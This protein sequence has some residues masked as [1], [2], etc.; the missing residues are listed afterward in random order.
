MQRLAPDDVLGRVFG[1]VEGTY[2]ASAAAGS[3]PRRRS[4]SPLLGVE[5]ALVADRR[6]PA[7][8]CALALRAPLGRLEAGVPIPERQFGLL[9]GISLF[10]P[11]P[12][13]HAG[14]ARD[15]HGARAGA[16]AAS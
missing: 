5:G 9:R 6:L 4:P 13:G 11:L 2:V 8:C 16:Q 1:V 14:D 12:D 3:R 15:A 10:A 7:G